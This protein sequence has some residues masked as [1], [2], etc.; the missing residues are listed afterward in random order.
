M[1]QFVRGGALDIPD[2]SLHSSQTR[3]RM[4]RVSVE[5]MVA[6][7]DICNNWPLGQIIFVETAFLVRFAVRSAC[8]AFGTVPRSDPRAGRRGG[9]VT[10][11]RRL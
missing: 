9:A 10:P 6:G 11:V 1:S 4:N 2:F 7:C 8:D 5:S 3:Y